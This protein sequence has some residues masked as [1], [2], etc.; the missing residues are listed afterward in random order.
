[1]RIEL[2]FVCYLVLLLFIAA[3]GLRNYKSLSAPFK[4]LTFFIVYTCASEIATRFVQNGGPFYHFFFPVQYFVITTFFG[5]YVRKLNCY[6]NW[7]VPIFTILCLLNLVFY[8]D[9]YNIPSNSVLVGSLIFIICAL[10]LYQ[11]MLTEISEVRVYRNELFWF[12]T[13][14]LIQ[15]TITFFCWSFYNYFKKENFHTQYLIDI[16]YYVCLLYYV[17]IGISIYLNGKNN[18]HYSELNGT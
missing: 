16:V 2:R 3:V 11:K 5:A 9:I 14:V 8:Q 6:L 7:S 13:G 10:F 12:N 18:R 15:F 17:L 4:L 1:M